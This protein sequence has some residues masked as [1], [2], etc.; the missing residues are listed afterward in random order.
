VQPRDRRISKYVFVLVIGLALA[1]TLAAQQQ[2]ATPQ[3]PAQ[4]QAAPQ[5]PPPAE[6]VF[7]NIQVF[8][9]IPAPQL[10]PTMQFIAASLGVQC[11]YCH[12]PG[13]FEKDDKPAKATARRMIQMTMA[14]N[15]ESFDGNR[16]VNCYTCHRGAARPVSI[17]AVMQWSVA[18]SAPNAPAAG[19]GP[20]ASAAPA[21]PTADQILAKYA[22]AL[23][24]R[25]AAEKLTTRVRTGALEAP[26]GFRMSVESYQKAPDKSL[27]ILHTPQ[28]DTFQVVNGATAWVLPA[29]T[30]TPREVAGLDLAR[31]RRDSLFYGDFDLKQAYSGF[32]VRGIEKVGDRDA[33]L[34]IASAPNDVPERLYFDTQ[35]GLLLRR[36]QYTDSA[37]GRFP[38]QIDYEDYREVDGIKRAFVQRQARPD[39]VIVVKWDSIKHNVPVDDARFERPAA[40]APAP[41]K[42]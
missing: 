23:G 16:D 41:A 39:F 14:I 18:G 6:Q 33:Y 13:E 11:N 32:R 42:P 38:L 36:V 20:G 40:P 1:A 3:K 24:G 25:A 15:R 37:L 4:P 26:G 17:P 12:V 2:Q 5:G 27:V 29:E 19:G 8:K 31:A 28:G 34:V 22:E 35:T 21:M 10:Q 7:K 9:G 30:K